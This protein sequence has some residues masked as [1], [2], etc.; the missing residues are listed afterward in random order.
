MPDFASRSEASTSCVLFPLPVLSVPD[1]QKVLQGQIR[2]QFYLHE[3]MRTFCLYN[4]QLLQN[5][6]KITSEGQIPNLAL[7]GIG[8][9]ADEVQK[10]KS[11][12]KHRTYVHFWQNFGAPI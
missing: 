8:D 9:L 6:H 1:V 7:G 10:P 2:R 3:D 12:K 5:Y 11:H 4:R